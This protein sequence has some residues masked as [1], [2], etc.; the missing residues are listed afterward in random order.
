M[1]PAMQALQD[2]IAATIDRHIRPLFN[3]DFHPQ[4]RVTVLVRFDD[5]PTCD[6]LVTSDTDAGIRAIVERRTAA[7]TSGQKGGA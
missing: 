5:A 4:M 1:S 6:V 7:G 3:T 2:Q